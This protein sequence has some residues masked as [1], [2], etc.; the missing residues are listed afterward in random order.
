MLI[1]G[2]CFGLQK[3]RFHLWDDR[4]G[5]LVFF[6]R[7]TVCLVDAHQVTYAVVFF[8]ERKPCGGGNEL[9]F[10]PAGGMK[11]IKIFQAKSGV[12]SSCRSLIWYH[13]DR[14]SFWSLRDEPAGRETHHSRESHRRPS[15]QQDDRSP[16]RPSDAKTIMGCEPVLRRSGLLEHPRSVRAFIRPTL[17][18]SPSAV[19]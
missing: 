18:R 1:P 16:D 5:R 3:G 12:L 11:M 13:L 6:Y 15:R 14:V 9:W 19:N 17:D 2:R 4:L 7:S 10:Q 8:L